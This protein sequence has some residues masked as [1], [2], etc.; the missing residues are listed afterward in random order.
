[1][2]EKEL[3]MNDVREEWFEKLHGGPTHETPANLDKFGTNKETDYGLST[4]KESNNT[5]EWEK[6]NRI[7]D[8]LN[9]TE[10]QEPSNLDKFE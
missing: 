4:P 2:V 6:R 10:K 9:P 5:P 8:I 1:M 3:N 7:H